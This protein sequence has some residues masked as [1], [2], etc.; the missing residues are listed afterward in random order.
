[1]IQYKEGFIVG[2]PLKSPTGQNPVI[3][4]NSYTN[5]GALPDV[6]TTVD[7]SAIV[8]VGTKSVCLDGILIITHGNTSET[9]DL[10]VSFRLPSETYEYGYIM[11]TIEA[12]ILNGQRSNASTWVSLDDN[13]C[14]QYKW[15]KSTSGTY[16]TNS[17]YGINLSVTAYV[18]GDIEDIF[19]MQTKI[20]ILEST[21]I[22]MQEQI[23][24]LQSK[25]Y[26]ED[27]RITDIINFF[28]T[29]Q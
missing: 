2:A 16:P 24:D 18:R 25:T 10:T 28:K 7:L 5:A 23:L 20:D 9:A 27:T 19:T 22:G 26:S 21:I 29:F 11:Q 15:S 17:S 6:W 4:V 14:F 8:P 13:R 3:F 12:S 1:M